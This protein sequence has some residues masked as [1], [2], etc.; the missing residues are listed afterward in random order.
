MESPQGATDEYA[1]F[2]EVRLNLF[3]GP[4]DLL[5]HLVKQNELPIEKL[6]LAEVAQQYLQCL[7][8]MRYFDLEIAGEYLVIAATLLSIKSSILLNEPVA[9]VIDEDG[10][11]VNPHDQL[12][13]RLR[14]AAV[15]KECA[16]KL[17][18]RT[19][20]GYDVFGS[21]ST[22]DGV[23]A[24]PVKYKDH[25]PILLGKAFRKLLAQA[26]KR[27]EYS[28]QLESVSVVERMMT[29]LSQLKSEGGSVEFHKLVPDLTSR[30]SI[31][32]SFC[33]LLELCKRHVITVKQ[34][35]TFEM[36]YV[37]LAS[38]DFDP[39]RFYEDGQIKSEFDAEVVDEEVVDDVPADATANG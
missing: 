36:I 17:A 22:L 4:I 8:Q 18:E 31:V 13:Q 29:I 19:L 5:L 9:L 30:A 28:V 14:E 11:L 35:Q 7:E 24:P 16:L 6:S 38:A 32:G 20:L 10:N 25:A 37:V 34:D 21:P 27:G 12:L 23:D 15:Y 1:H 33:A 3:D 39:E 2:F 26:N